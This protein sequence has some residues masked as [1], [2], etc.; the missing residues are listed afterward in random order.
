MNVGNWV[1]VSVV[2]LIALIALAGCVNSPPVGESN[3]IEI[4]YHTLRGGMPVLIAQEKGFFADEGLDV[5][6]VGFET[7]QP[8]LDSVLSGS[9]DMG[10]YTAI[11]IIYSGVLRSKTDLYFST[12]MLEDA[13]HRISILL[14]R[15]DEPESFSISDLKG[16][17]IGVLPTLAYRV[18]MEELLKRNGIALSEVEI[19]QVNQALSASA[20]KTGQ[21]DAL[22]TLD[23][24]VTTIIQNGIGRPLYDYAEVPAMFGEPFLF[25]TFSFR[26]DFVEKNPATTQ[27]VIRALDRAIVFINENQQ[28]SK[29]IFAKYLPQAQGAYAEYFPDSRFVTSDEVDPEWFARQAKLYYDLNMVSEQLPAQDWVI[30]QSDFE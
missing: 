19:V 2:L 25:V 6:L 5:K 10:G 29:R 30:S 23:P 15:A 14:I 22:F 8:L 4:G 1:S 7:A 16:K 11:P 3:T 24:A 17:K 20:L 28:E 26:K 12:G 9:L 18:W 27:K 21:V 13:N